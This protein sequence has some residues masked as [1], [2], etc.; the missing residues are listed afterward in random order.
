MT[1]AAVKKRLHLAVEHLQEAGV[2]D[3][4]IAFEGTDED[5]SVHPYVL[6]I[7]SPMACLAL[8]QFA[9][10]YLEQQRNSGIYQN[11]DDDED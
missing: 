2:R 1:P 6:R 5:G 11:E 3:C 4:M 10:D 8:A 9:S 7:G